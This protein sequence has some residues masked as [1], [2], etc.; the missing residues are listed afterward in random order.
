MRDSINGN[1]RSTRANTV[2]SP[3]RYVLQVGNASDIGGDDWLALLTT[4]SITCSV[5]VSPD[6]SVTCKSRRA[7]PPESPLQT[8]NEL[9]WFSTVDV[10][11]NNEMSVIGPG[12]GM[13]CNTFVAPQPSKVITSVDVGSSSKRCRVL[14]RAGFGGKNGSLKSE[15]RYT[16]A[17]SKLDEPPP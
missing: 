6:G 10:K 9:A 15:Y 3:G 12:R 11:V 2:L 17:K 1:S 8:V 13:A 14:P 5:T 4:P 7:G 16:S